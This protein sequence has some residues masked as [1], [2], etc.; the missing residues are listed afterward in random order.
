MAI[1][2]ILEP[3]PHLLNT[4]SENVHCWLHTTTILG[5][6]H[7]DQEGRGYTK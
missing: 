5:T 6:L 7:D 1:D 2:I 4:F 3:T